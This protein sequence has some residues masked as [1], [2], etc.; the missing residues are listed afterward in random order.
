MITNVFKLQIESGKFLAVLD[1][2]SPDLLQLLSERMKT[3]QKNVT[4]DMA[5]E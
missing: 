2:K 1:A 4:D 3:I 5:T